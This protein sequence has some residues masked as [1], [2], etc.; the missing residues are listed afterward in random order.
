MGFRCGIVG[1]PNVGKSTIFNALTALQVEASAYPFCTISPN[2]G[3]VPVE[4]SRLSIIQELFG[5][6]KS[7]PTTLEFIDIAGL[8]RGASQGEG[9][10]NQ[11]LSHIQ[12]TDA[13]A[14]VIRCF[15]DENV[16]HVEHTLDPVRD[17]EVVNY[18]LLLKDLEIVEKRLA[19]VSKTL[20][21]G[22]AAVKEECDVLNLA[23]THLTAGKTLQHLVLEPQQIQILKAINLLTLKPMFYIAN[24]D[25]NHLKS[26]SWVEALQAY[27]QKNQQVCLTFCGKAQAEISQLEPEN[28]KEFLEAMGLDE[29]GL[30]KVIRTGY[31]ILNLITFFTANK[32]ETHAW[33]IEQNTKVQKAAGLVHTDFE[34]NFIKAEVIKFDDLNLCRSIPGLHERGLVSIHG[35]DYIV[36]DGDLILIK[37]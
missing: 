30:A 1:L 29:F 13:L 36:Q 17:A 11:F 18:E 22:S 8:V 12:A 9:L 24:V 7:T 3:M 32:N 33:T 31:E 27:A 4:D 34:R 37:T 23:L 2:V 20:R 10:G 6:E 28:R 25:E 21:L 15:V 16:A 26:N 14:Q 5:S 35:R 19:K